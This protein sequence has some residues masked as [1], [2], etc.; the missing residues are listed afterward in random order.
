MRKA[1]RERIEEK[2]EDCNSHYIM[3][4]VRATYLLAW[5]LF[6]HFIIP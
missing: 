4:E 3:N 5:R 6:I 2:E 1:R